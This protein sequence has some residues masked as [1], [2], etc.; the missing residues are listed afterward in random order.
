MCKYLCLHH[1][2]VLGGVRAWYL[3]VTRN[4]INSSNRCS[5]ADYKFQRV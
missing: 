4:K 3:V 2:V 1:V 5:Q